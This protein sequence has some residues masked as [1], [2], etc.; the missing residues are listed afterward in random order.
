MILLLTIS[1]DGTSDRICSRLEGRIFRFNIDQATEYQLCF[2]PG[3]WEIINPAGLR[4][5]NLTASGVFFWKA[6]SVVFPQIDRLVR[7][8]VRYIFWELYSSFPAHKRKG[9]SPN[10]HDEYGK[11]R[12]LNIA[13]EFFNVPASVYTHRLHGE[14]LVDKRHRVAKSLSSMLTS[15]GKCLFTSDVSDRNI[16]PQFPWFIQEKVI[17]EFDMTTFMAGERMF[18]FKRSRKNLSGLD[19]RSEQTLSESSQEWEF[20]VPPEAFGGKLFALSQ[21][22]GV[23]WGRFDF[24]ISPD[25]DFIFLEYNANGQFVF[26]DLQDRHGLIDAVA[27]YLV[28]G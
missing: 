10:F 17:S 20:F 1:R 24:M 6:F 25:G 23:N 21:R 15:D 3:S 28:G 11:L 12:I 7:S 22:L 5:T 19:W 4:I 9:T 2:T 14:N 18:S 8:E 27:H 13:N 26:L 16:D